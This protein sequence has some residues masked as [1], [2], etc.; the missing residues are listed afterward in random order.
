LNYLQGWARKVHRKGKYLFVHLDDGLN[1]SGNDKDNSHNGSMLQV[2]IPRSLCHSVMVGTALELSG[3]W[4][5]SQGSKQPMEL[6]AS[7]C[8]PI[9]DN[10]LCELLMF[11]DVEAYS[12]I[13]EKLFRVYIEAVIGFRL[14]CDIYTIK[15]I[16]ETSDAMRQRLHL[17]PLS[18]NF[19]SVLRLRSQLNVIS[20]QFYEKE[21]FIEIDTPMISCNDCE[22]AGEA[23]L[24]KVVVS[25]FIHELI[26]IIY[27]SAIMIVLA[28]E[29]E[30][31]FGDNR[32][33]LP[34]SS[35]L[36][37]EAVISGISKVY[38]LSPAFRAEKSLSRQHLAEFRMLEAEIA[39]LDDLDELC[40][41][42]ERFVRF[43][44]ERLK[45]STCV[46]TDYNNMSNTFCDQVVIAI[47]VV[48]F[49]FCQYS[50]IR[51]LIALCK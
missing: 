1:N 2:V 5:R 8:K 33:Y 27:S 16:A 44:I 34:V 36:H 35:Q 51:Y 45:Q 19:R 7:K 22:G 18:S 39:F 17:R 14:S 49:F 47:I 9:T 46:Q 11:S 3:E 50:C 43:V 38:T 40:S 10:P 24:V 13:R 32:F 37:L 41:F 28:Q 42:V 6:F 15:T 12:V 26:S 21:G 4:T 30:D 20:R 31:F 48:D 29:D 25:D 23:F